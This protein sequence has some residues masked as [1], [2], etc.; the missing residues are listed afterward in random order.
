MG[1]QICR[2]VEEEVLHDKQSRE[3]GDV[4]VAT[5]TL[6]EAGHQL[7][8]GMDIQL[9]GRRGIWVRR[10]PPAGVLLLGPWSFP[11]RTTEFTT[12]H[13][14]PRS[15]WCGSMGVGASAVKPS[16]KPSGTSMMRHHENERRGPNSHSVS[17]VGRA[18]RGP[19]RVT[20]PG[21]WQVAKRGCLATRRRLRTPPP[22]KAN[23]RAQTDA[24]RQR[25]EATNRGRVPMTKEC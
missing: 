1:H 16:A 3:V 19:G 10:Q 13:L 24:R 6:E 21:K 2:W 4:Q 11:T 25:P 12:V 17:H 23:S 20:R 8:W 22:N 18:T 7:R 15:K 5:N 9:P 14:S